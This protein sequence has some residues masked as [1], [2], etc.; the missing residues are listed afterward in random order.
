MI[1]SR[2][3][4]RGR[5]MNRRGQAL[6]EFALVFPIAM[7]I[8]FG[9]I[10]FGLYVFYQQQLT[11]VAR[12]GARHAAIHSWGALCPTS[13]WRDPQAPPST[14]SEKPL[15]CDGPDRAGDPYPWPRMTEHARSFAW[16]MNPG[17]IHINACWSGYRGPT[18]PPSTNADSP[19]I[20]DDGVSPPITNVFIPCTIAGIDPRTNPQALGC[21][22]R[23][24]TLADDPASNKDGNQV[25][26]YACFQWV[27]PLAGVLM[28]PS[29]ITLKAAVTEVI[30]RQQ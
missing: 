17:A 30:Q 7:I 6:V 9:I 18:S 24:T 4:A 23:M 25:T 3:A 26:V 5:G 8:I 13:S 19:P 11:N 22:T 21:G 20:T 10:V 27:P 28:L 12:E 29:S 1:G 2:P 16:G 14:Y 15:N